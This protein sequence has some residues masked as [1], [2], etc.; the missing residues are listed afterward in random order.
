MHDIVF[1][2]EL[3]LY[4]LILY[5]NLLIDMTRL[6]FIICYFTILL[7]GRWFLYLFLLHATDNISIHFYLS[8]K[9]CNA[10]MNLAQIIIICLDWLNYDFTSLKSMFRWVSMLEEDIQQLSYKYFPFFVCWNLR[11]LGIL[12]IYF[13]ILKL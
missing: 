6:T 10:I 5:D 8:L 1:S 7:Q 2:F 11:D 9:S 4:L 13:V 12:Y 3:L